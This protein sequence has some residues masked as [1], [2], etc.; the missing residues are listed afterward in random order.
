MSPVRFRFPAVPLTLVAF[1]KLKSSLVC[2]TSSEQTACPLLCPMCPV[3]SAWFVSIDRLPRPFHILLYRFWVAK[4]NSSSIQYRNCNQLFS[5]L[6]SEDVS[7]LETLLPSFPSE[8]C[9]NPSCVR[10]IT[11][12]AVNSQRSRPTGGAWST[13]RSSTICCRKMSLVSAFGALFYSAIY[14]PRY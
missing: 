9:F 12:S 3:R 13:S 1:A 8:P 5:A 10:R 11:S 2:T 14:S 4:R 7:M 6:L